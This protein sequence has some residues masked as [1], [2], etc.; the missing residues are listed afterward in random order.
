MKM[1]MMILAVVA[2][3]I[4]FYSCNGVDMHDQMSQD[5]LVALEGMR[6]ASTGS[7]DANVDFNGAV[8]QDDSHGIYFY[9]SVFH[10]FEG[11]FEEHHANYSHAN[12]HDDHHHD[13]DG[14]HMGATAMNGHGR[15]DG[16]HRDDHDLMNDLIT[17]H[18][19]IQH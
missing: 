12:D 10:H 15:Q 5:D 1:T 19:S 6:V 14:M 17:D 2:I 16:H 13:P 4:G 8:Q 9:D 11:L 3:S 7:F 18:V